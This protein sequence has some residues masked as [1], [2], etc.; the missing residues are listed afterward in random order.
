[1]D[2]FF[3]FEKL[4]YVHSKKPNECILCLLH[5]GSDQVEDLTVYRDNF[6]TATINL[7]PYNP[8]H[9]LIFPNRHIEDIRNYTEKE[10]IRLIRL[11]QHFVQILDTLQKPH[12]FNIGYNM[13][14]TA[15]ASISHLHLH[16]IPRYPHEL[17]IADLIAQKRVL[18]ENPYDTRD[19]LKQALNDHP[20]PYSQSD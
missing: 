5:K 4:T 8:G 7:Y 9:I 17:G 6:F 10:A 16:I 1:M 20:F 19:R 11:E 15:G 18:V 12:G 3:N 14:L 2:Y 13:G